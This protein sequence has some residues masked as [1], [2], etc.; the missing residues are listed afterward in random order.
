MDKLLNA[1]KEQLEK[2]ITAYFPSGLS[3]YSIQGG[4]CSACTQEI[5][6]LC[7][8]YYHLQSCGIRL[9][10]SP[11]DADILMISGLSS[12][13][14]AELIFKSYQAMKSLKMVIAVGECTNTGHCFKESPLFYGILNKIIPVTGKVV[15]C[16]PSPQTLMAGILKALSMKLYENS[17]LR[18]QQLREKINH[19][20]TQKTQLEQQHV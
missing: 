19:L 1:P 4:K 7:G 6:S 5:A 13:D 12:K 16:P 10:K 11:K 17:K 2:L 15:G 9:T 20:E 8:P 14:D 18:S 3:L